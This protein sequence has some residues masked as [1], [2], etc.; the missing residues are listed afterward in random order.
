MNNA[1]GLKKNLL[2]ILND[3]K[4]S[5]CPRV[6]GLAEYLDRLRM[7]PFY[8]GLKSEVPEAAQQGAAARRPGRAV[9]GAG[10]GRRS[11]P[12]CT[13]ACSSRSWASATSARS[14]ATTSR[15]LRK[16]LTMV[17]DVDGP[18]AAARGDREGARLPAGRRRPGVLPHAGPVRPRTTNGVVSFKKSSSQ[19]VH[20]RRPRRDLRRR[21]RRNPQRHRDDRRHV[22]GQQARAGPRR[23]SPTGSSTPASASRTPWPSPPAWPR[24]AC[25]RSSTSTARSCSGATTRSSRKWPCRTCRSRSCS[26]APA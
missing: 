17:K 2:V 15:Q 16:Y 10:Q 8:T 11:R 9:P 18:G 1:G 19:A 23:R 26:T 4:M 13:A 21:C 6:G 20:R 3:N 25:G 7:N 14:T 24:P 5:I 22:P 12:A